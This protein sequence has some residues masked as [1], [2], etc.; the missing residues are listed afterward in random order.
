MICRRSV[1]LS[2]FAGLA[3]PWLAG[4]GAQAGGPTGGSGAQGSGG[5]KIV[6]TTGMV[7]DTVRRVGEDRVQLKVLMGPGVD[8]HLYK[9]SE[10]VIDTLSNADCIFYSG[11]HLEGKMQD[12]LEK[13]G[14]SGKPTVPV[15]AGINPTKLRTPAQ[16]QGH[17]DP[18]IWFDVSLWKETVQPV[19]EAL[20]RL[21]PSEKATFEARGKMYEADLDALH[22]EC[23]DTLKRIPKAQRVLVTAHDAFGYF[24]RAY[25]IE[26]VGLQ[27]ISTASEFGQADVARIRDLIVARK[28]RAVFVES[29]VPPRSIE[30]VVAGCRSQGHEVKIGGTLYSDAMG[31][32][33]TE[34]GTYLGMVRHN[35][36]A[37]VQALK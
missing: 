34:S 18:H 25:D 3:S 26:V 10:N 31:A 4:C 30:A 7:G 20:S 24:G 13:I 21:L 33:G 2:G 22:L 35:V 9:P 37:M 19:V 5:L 14:A 36:N 12:I 8:P 29:S 27:G 17:P 11:L 28:V 15:G 16:F 23:I 1:L 6:A 32:A